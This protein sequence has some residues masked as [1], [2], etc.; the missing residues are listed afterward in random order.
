MAKVKTLK[1]WTHL[2]A[3]KRVPTEYEIVS[4]NAI[5]NA[6]N[7]MRPLEAASDLP[8]NQWLRHYRTDSRLQHSDWNG[9]RDPDQVTYR[10]YTC[11]RHDREVFVDGLLDRSNAL[12][13]D[14]QLSPSWAEALATLYAPARYLMHCVQIG[15]AYLNLM[16]PAST[17]SN[18]AAF[19]AADALRWVSRIAYRTTE[20]AEH[21]PALGFTQ[22]ERAVWEDH[23]AWQGFRELM[24]RV[25]VAYDFGETVVA[26]NVVAKSAIDAA[27]GVQLGAAA[28]AQ[29]DELTAHLADEF[30]RDS[31]YSQRWTGAFLDYARRE[32]DNTAVINDWSRKWKPLA[33]RAI[34]AFVEHLPEPDSAKAQAHDYL[35]KAMHE[36]RV[37]AGRG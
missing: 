10:K 9:F 5:Y 6:D 18:A 17:F 3:N 12:G 2:A 26:L 23:A 16:S 28:R 31:T 21:W 22:Q 36:F 27:F 32:G 7:P 8:M 19:Q 37:E 11:E 13:C 24:E 29:G 1:T 4:T 34:D 20:L 25:L 15:S 33:Q 35:V 30:L 14:R